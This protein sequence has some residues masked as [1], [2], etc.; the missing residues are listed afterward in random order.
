MV[1]RS[2]ATKSLDPEEMEAWEQ[3]RRVRNT[4]QHLTLQDMEL[5][6]GR[7]DILHWLR[8]LSPEMRESNGY[9]L[10][11]KTEADL[12]NVCSSYR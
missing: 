12:N 10:L 1:A 11:G 7:T 3:K 8:D 9:C 5:L 2:V 6:R 4:L